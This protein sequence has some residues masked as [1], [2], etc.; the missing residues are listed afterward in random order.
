MMGLVENNHIAVRQKKAADGRVEQQQGVIDDD[1]LSHFGT[2]PH[3]TH[4]AIHKVAALVPGALIAISSNA[5]TNIARE[6]EAER[7]KIAREVGIGIVDDVEQALKLAVAR[8]VLHA[9]PF[10]FHTVNAEIVIDALH[11]CR[12]EMLDMLLHKGNIFIKKLLL[13]RLIGGADN[14]YLAGAHDRQEVGQTIMGGN[15]GSAR[16]VEMARSIDLDTTHRTRGH[17]THSHNVTEAIA[18]RTIV[19]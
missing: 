8:I 3:L 6:L 11:Q 10:A 9:H 2:L 19:A 17:F 12:L 5:T 13:Q 1:H 16:E 18:F 14:R 15:H 7:L 4:V